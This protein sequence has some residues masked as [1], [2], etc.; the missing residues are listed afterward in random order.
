[1]DKDAMALDTNAANTQYSVSGKS[2]LVTGGTRGVGRAISLRFARSGANVLANFV[3]DVAA[4]ESLVEQAQTEKI[5]IRTV[6]ADLTQSGGLD[7]LMQELQASFADLG[8]LVHCAATGVHKPVEEIQLRQF[9]WTFALNVRAFVELVRRTLPMMQ[10]G[11]SIL[12]ISSEGAVRAVPQYAL[13]GASKGALEA[14]LRHMAAEL[15][16][17][18]IRVN[19]ISPGTL[20]TD[21][22]KVLPDSERRLAEA[23]RRSPVG[24]LATVEQVAQV[25]KFLASPD[26]SYMTGAFVTVDGGASTILGVGAPL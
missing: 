6:R 20:M 26:S 16:A 4:A 1:M 8:C 15:A 2:V 22:W 19:A 11:A 13:V 17:K 10:P 12:G 21:V 23:A 5:S 24:R 9:D 14:L 3:R 25:I 7:R 18:G